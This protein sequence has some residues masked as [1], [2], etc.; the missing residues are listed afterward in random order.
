MDHIGACQF[1]Y[2]SDVKDDPKT[3]HYIRC[4][5]CTQVYTKYIVH[6]MQQHTCTCVCVRERHRKGKGETGRNRESMQERKRDGERK[7]GV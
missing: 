4:T 2:I 6:S 5:K 1:C 7:M 3:R